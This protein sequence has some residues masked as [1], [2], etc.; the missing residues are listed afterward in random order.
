MPTNN[1]NGIRNFSA[2]ASHSPYL[3]RALLLRKITAIIAQT[4]TTI[5]DCQR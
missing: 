2:A 3:K 4:P 1:E 5:V